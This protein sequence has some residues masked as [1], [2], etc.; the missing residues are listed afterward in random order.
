VPVTISGWGLREGAAV[1]LFPLAGSTA[2]G[3]LAT[4]VAFGLMLIV[5]SLP[6]SL[7]VLGRARRGQVGP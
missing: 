3:G 1:V 2:S 4:S 5:A 6:G 7:A